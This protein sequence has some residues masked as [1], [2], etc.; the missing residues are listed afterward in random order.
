MKTAN[1]P[2]HLVLEVQLNVA[3]GL[4]LVFDQEG[5]IYRRCITRE[6]GACFALVALVVNTKRHAE[7]G[8]VQF[9][10][11]FVQLRRGRHYVFNSESD[12]E[13]FEGTEMTQ[14]FLAR[15][16]KQR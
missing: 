6:S 3:V 14:V 4:R 12:N 10:G 2:R 11:T 1:T 8:V 13:T 5:N 7:G 9:T 16:R 15:R